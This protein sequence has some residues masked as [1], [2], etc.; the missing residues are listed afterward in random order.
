MN[1]YP[2]KLKI[3]FPM[4][5]A[6]DYRHHLTAIDDALIV[7]RRVDGEFL[8]QLDSLRKL[9]AR[10]FAR[11]LIDLAA[12]LEA[13]YTLMI[14]DRDRFLTELEALARK[15]ASAKERDEVERSAQ[16]VAEHVQYRIR[17]HLDASIQYKA[18][19]MIIASRARRTK[20]DPGESSGLNSQH[21]I[22]TPRSEQLWHT[23]IDELCEV[24]TVHRGLAAWHRWTRANRPSIPSSAR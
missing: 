18:A 3:L 11:C 12:D 24:R 17:D 14:V 22:P 5:Q 9:G 23:V 2:T 1:L 6:K 4:Y 15:H 20:A 7:H 21:G 19:R 16:L 13:G 8:L 10:S